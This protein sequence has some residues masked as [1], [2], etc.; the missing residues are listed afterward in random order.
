M[1]NLKSQYQI[2]KSNSDE[3]EEVSERTV[4]ETLADHFNPLYPI[5]SQMLQGKEIIAKHE[6]YRRIN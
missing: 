4:M 1:D 5:L 2:K 6:I 3:W